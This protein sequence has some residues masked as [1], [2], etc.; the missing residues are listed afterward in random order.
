[1]KFINSLFVAV[2]AIFVGNTA[3]AETANH[4]KT[5]TKTTKQVKQPVKAQ[6]AKPQAAK[7]QQ[8]KQQVAK[9]QP[10]KK[11][12]VAMTNAQ[13]LDAFNKSIGIRLVARDLVTDKQNN[14]LVSL[15]YEIENRGNTPIKSVNWVNI[16]AVGKTVFHQQPLP[17]QF[18]TPFAGKAK[19]RLNLELAFSTL[20]KEAQAI[21][22]DPNQRISSVTIARQI[23]FANGKQ[24][25]VKN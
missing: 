8:A 3:N 5:N 14:K 2:L 19:I 15:S 4:S 7:P 23:V 25:N 18:E 11:K 21:F 24:I 9:K 13:A 6:H 16:Y 17:L 1:M 22:S 20:S 12:P 10:V